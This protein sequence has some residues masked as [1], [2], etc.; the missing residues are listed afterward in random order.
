[1]EH[2]ESIFTNAFNFSVEF[3]QLEIPF[4]LLLVIVIRKAIKTHKEQLNAAWSCSL[5]KL[6]HVCSYQWQATMTSSE[7]EN[8][9][10][11][12]NRP[13]VCWLTT[14]NY[15]ATTT[16]SHTHTHRDTLAHP[17][18]GVSDIQLWNQPLNME[19]FRSG[20]DG[21]I[22]RCLLTWSSVL[23]PRPHKDWC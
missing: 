4:S 11:D 14:L 17:L 10:I 6:L 3:T 9:L 21:S 23:M 1:M 18:S 22:D 12:F 19:S 15:D 5:L 2:K 16:P 20:R 7:Y 8:T 13:T